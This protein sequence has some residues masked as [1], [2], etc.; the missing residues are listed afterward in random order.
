M[1]DASKAMLGMHFDE[2]DLK[3]HGFDIG[4]VRVVVYRNSLV[5]FHPCHFVTVQVGMQ[6]AA[7]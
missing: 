5:K 4:Y 2:L 6:E 3:G 1:P 7:T